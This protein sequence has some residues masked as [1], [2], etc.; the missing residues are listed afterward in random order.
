MMKKT[1]QKIVDWFKRIIAKIKRIF[2]KSEVN[3][4]DNHPTPSDAIDKI[5]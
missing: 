2:S 3:G 1:L 4:K 5:E